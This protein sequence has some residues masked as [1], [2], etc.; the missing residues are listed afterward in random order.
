MS[1]VVFDFDKT[2][3]TKDTFNMFMYFCG[4]QDKFYSIKILMYSIFIVLR[5]LRLIGNL[6]QKQVALRIFLPR[7]NI[8]LNNYAKEF[9][10]NIPLNH[11]IV[12]LLNKKQ[13]EHNIIICSAS[14]SNYIKLL[15]PGF[16]VIGMEYNCTTQEITQHPYKREKLTYLKKAGIN[17]IDELYT[18]SYS[19]KYLAMIAR[20]IFV[21]ERGNI[22]KYN[23]YDSFRKHFRKYS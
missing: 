11:K 14:L 18:D 20:K 9:I 7:E 16:K 1:I 2:I 19:D 22:H 4:K 23:D 17:K 21:V 8:I 12:A 13:K 15:L 3:T 10:K 5:K 6:K